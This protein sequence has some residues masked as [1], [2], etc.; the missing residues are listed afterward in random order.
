M[1][2]LTFDAD[3]TPAMVQDL[4]SGRVQRFVNDG[5][6]ATLRELQVPATFFLSGLWMEKYPDVAR[7]IAA[8][9]AFEVASHGYS[10]QAFR[11]GCFTLPTIDLTRARDDLDR[12]Q[13]I[14]DGVSTH[15]TRYFRFPGGCYD[16]AALAAIRPANLQVI[17][18]D[19][20]SGDT[21]ASDPAKVSAQVVAGAQSG[22]IVVLH[23]T[24]G[25]AAPVTDKALPGIVK[26]L[27]AR[28]F[29]LVRVSDLLRPG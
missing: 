9:P 23:V 27:R 29:Q 26:Q 2:A 7:D 3:M 20:L 6:I 17:Q 15:P 24:G 5:V 21:F 18:Y 4:Q 1:V 13:T 22:S 28:G 10:Q 8:D 19:V 25:N 11:A 14:L 12:N 16:A